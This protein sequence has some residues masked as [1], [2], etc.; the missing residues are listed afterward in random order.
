MIDFITKLYEQLTNE[1]A[2][3]AYLDG[4]CKPCKAVMNYKGQYLD[5]ENYEHFI[6]PSVLFQYSISRLNDNDGVLEATITLHLCYEKILDDS[7]FSPNLDKALEY[8]RFNAVT[9]QLIK[10]LQSK[11]VGKLRFETEDQQKTDA[12]VSVHT[13]T[14][15]ASYLGRLNKLKEYDYKE[16]TATELSGGII[17]KLKDPEYTFD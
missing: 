14:F 4:N 16:N 8:H 3:Q 9:Y 11:E 12:I 7:S 10:D 1:D 17:E 15:T 2:K 13:M 5:F 6:C